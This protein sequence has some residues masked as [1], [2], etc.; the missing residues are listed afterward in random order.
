ME[1]FFSL[2]IEEK[3]WGVLFRKK[4]DGAYPYREG[5]AIHEHKLKERIGCI[6]VNLPTGGQ[7]FGTGFRVGERHVLTAY[8]VVQG[9]YGN[10]CCLL[11]K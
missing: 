1:S 2:I 10:C 9:V 5:E 8:H 6:T 11:Y 7:D 4:V 3:G